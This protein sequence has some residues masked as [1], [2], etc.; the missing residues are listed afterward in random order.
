MKRRQRLKTLEQLAA[1]AEADSSRRL[2]EKLARLRAE[3]QRLGQVHGYLDEYQ[4]PPQRPVSSTISELR[5]RRNFVDRLR[6]AVSEQHGVVDV[7]RRNAE[8]QATAWRAARSRT[9]ALQR[10]G[11][12]L[13]QQETQERDRRE[14]RS[15]D[16]VAVRRAGPGR[17]P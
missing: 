7:Q 14:Q 6:L 8:Q 16:E 11:E 15:L 13:Q 17:K 9:L 12:R 4:R 10:L 1:H 5:S 3:E 2:G